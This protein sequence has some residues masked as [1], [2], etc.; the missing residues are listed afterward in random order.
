MESNRNEL[1]S[2]SSDMLTSAVVGTL[3]AT[4]VPAN[5][6]PAGTRLL[7]RISYPY[8]RVL[9]LPG[10]TRVPIDSSNADMNFT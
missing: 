4:R 5:L 9:Q 2:C 10:G 3:F 6:L 7:D 1:M 8:P